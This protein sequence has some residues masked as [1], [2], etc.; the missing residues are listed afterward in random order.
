VDAAF[1]VKKGD[2]GG[3]NHGAAGVT[4]NANSG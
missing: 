3:A 2:P 1:A 4:E